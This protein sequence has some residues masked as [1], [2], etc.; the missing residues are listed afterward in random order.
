MKTNFTVKLVRINSQGYVN[1]RYFGVNYLAAN[2]DIMRLYQVCDLDGTVLG[3]HRC[4]SR[5][6]AI[7]QATAAIAKADK[8]HAN[9]GIGIVPG[10][11]YI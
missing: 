4:A 7:A 5:K 10:W 8:F 2:G 9:S 11:D 6:D 3:Y 1:G